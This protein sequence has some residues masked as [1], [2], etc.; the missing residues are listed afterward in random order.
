MKITDYLS[1][2]K[3]HVSFEILPPLKGKSI[4]TIFQ[5]LD[6]LMEFKPPFINVT[7]HRSEYIYKKNHD[8]TFEKVVVRKRPGTVSM[9]AAIMSKYKIDAV[10]H[11][12]CGGFTKDQTEDALIDLHFLGV[13]NILALRG[14]AMKSENVFTPEPSGNARAIDLV[15]QAMNMNKGIYLEDDLTNGH[16]TDFCIGVAGYPE[17]HS[18]APNLKADIKHLKAKVDAGA[19]FVV[20]QM[21]WDNQ[22]YFDYVDLCRAEGINVPI[23]PGIKPITN[24]KQLTT[25]PRSF[26]VNLPDAL[27]DAIAKAKTDDDVKQVGIEWCIMQSKQLLQHNVPC[28]HYYIMSNLAEMLTIT[29]AVL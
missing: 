28:L 20:T 18:E 8:Q 19:S 14:D 12:I 1:Q 24:R 5:L 3:T 22:A 26:N 23:I 4:D 16:P 10:P 7:Y 15:Q 17:K 11:L 25:I 21:F 27:C 29:R 6:P 13:K 9:C 2:E